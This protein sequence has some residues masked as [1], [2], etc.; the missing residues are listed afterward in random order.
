[1]I[2]VRKLDWKPNLGI[3]QKKVSARIFKDKAEARTGKS[4]VNLL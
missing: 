1:M 3:E 4:Y 2:T